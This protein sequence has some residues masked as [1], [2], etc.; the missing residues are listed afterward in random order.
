MSFFVEH[1]ESIISGAVSALIVSAIMWYLRDVLIKK[2][3]RSKQAQYIRD[4]LIRYRK[5]IYAQGHRHR[6]SIEGRSMHHQRYAFDVMW[7]DL[8]TVL[9]KGTPDI[10]FSEKQEIVQILSHM[11]PSEVI[12]GKLLG[13]IEIYESIF[14]ELEN[15]EWLKLPRVTPL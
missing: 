9:E 10:T 11:I 12:C 14:N 8:E 6:G 5:M 2:R 7:K 13:G 1:Y 4:V 15:L 3:N